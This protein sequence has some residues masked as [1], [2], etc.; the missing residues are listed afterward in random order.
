MP[1]ISQIY[2]GDIM[3]KSLFSK[4]YIL[5]VVSATLF[6][7][8]SFMLNSVSG[9]YTMRL[10]A[11]KFMAGVVTCT[12]TLTSFFI[13]PLWG[14]ICDRKSRK[15]I[16]LTG[17][18]LCVLSSVMLIFTAQIRLLIAARAVFGAGYSALTTAG[19]TIVCDVVDEKQLGK[20]ISYYGIT[21]VLSQAVAPAAA[22]W[23]Y[24][25]GFPVLAMVVAAG[26][27]VV[28]RCGIFIRYN[29]S[30]F[31]NPEQ[32]F[33]VYE[34]T[35]LP[36][37]YTIIFFAMATASVY[38]FIPIMAQEREISGV[39]WFFAVSAAGLMISRIFNTKFSEKA[40][41]KRVFYI[42]AVLF[43][44]GF[45]AVAFSYNIF[46]LVAAGLVYGLGAGFVHPVVNTRAVKRCS[47]ADRGLATGTFMMSQDL[48]M[49]I[50]AVAWGIISEKAGFTAVYIIVAVL[51]VC[52]MYVFHKFLGTLL[53]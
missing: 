6:Y 4:N 25:I 48:G 27:A 40:G 37:A 21:N 8:A 7:I 36:A 15:F 41:E 26:T 51:A 5:V 9:R 10:G 45:A 18:L 50:G 2:L 35:A 16:F 32:K 14:W 44:T 31:V 13:R 30:D 39:G 3:E 1:I 46:V 33:R 20:A 24:G 23:L 49:T 34:K 17:S 29:Q 28:L 47:S 42:G 53:E 12:F 52:M 19:G 11:D 43:G 22:L 38:S